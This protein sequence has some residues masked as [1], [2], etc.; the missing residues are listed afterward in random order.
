MDAVVGA[1]E[2]LRLGL[3]DGKGVKPSGDVVGECTTTGLFLVGLMPDVRV[4]IGS[5]FKTNALNVVTII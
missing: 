1:I 4:P 5:Q 3:S 2:G